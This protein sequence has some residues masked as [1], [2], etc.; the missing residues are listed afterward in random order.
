MLNR[1]VSESLVCRRFKQLHFKI[2][3]LSRVAM[4]AGSLFHK[5]AKYSAVY[6]PSM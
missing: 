2:A 5:V 1:S 6:S 4:V 3:Y